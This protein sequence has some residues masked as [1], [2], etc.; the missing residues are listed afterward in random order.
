MRFVIDSLRMKEP[1]IEEI[2]VSKIGDKYGVYRI[3]NPR[4][5]VAVMKSIRKYGQ[6]TPVVCVKK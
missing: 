4:A 5:D 6:I 1:W 3:V 2:A